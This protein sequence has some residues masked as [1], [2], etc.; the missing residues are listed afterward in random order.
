MFRG[1]PLLD[2]V[3]DHRSQ[4]VV[5]CAD[6]VEVAGEVEV[7]VLH[8]HHLRIAAAGCAALDAKNGAEGRL[9]EAEHGLLAQRIHGV[10]QTHAGGRLALACGGGA[11]GCDEDQLALLR[12]LMDEAVVDLGLVAAIGDHVLVGKAQTG[13]DLCDG[14]HFGFLCDLDVRLHVQHPP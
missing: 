4:Q 6:G 7:D 8:R 12:G 10:G 3:V 9:A 5:G 11:D 13:G 14:L 1:L 2:A